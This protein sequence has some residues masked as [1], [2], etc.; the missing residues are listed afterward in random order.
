MKKISFEEIGELTVTFHALEGVKAGQAVKVAAD[1]TVG[2]C[3]A[4]ERICGA[5]VWA[6][7]GYAAVQM[8]GFISIP[9][10]G[11]VAPGWQKL[12]ADGKGGLTVNESGSEYL[13]ISADSA[14]GKA[15]VCL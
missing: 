14:A 2:P 10:T 6:E 3:A 1:S 13:V 12:A 8:K 5:A 11:A 9:Y 4:G 7:D 15:V